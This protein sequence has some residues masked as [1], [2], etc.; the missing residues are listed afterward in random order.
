[1]MFFENFWG[2]ATIGGAITRDGITCNFSVGKE[3]T[4]AMLRGREIAIQ[5][6]DMADPGWR[7]E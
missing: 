4:A 6:L 5:A 7:G 1:M 3:A 2:W